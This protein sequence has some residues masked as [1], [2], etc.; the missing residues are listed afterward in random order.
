MA[1]AT[2]S[3]TGAP[4]RSPSHVEDIHPSKVSHGDTALALLADGELQSAEPVELKRLVRKIDWTILPFLSVCYAFYYIDK[5]TLSYAAIFGIKEDLGLAGDQYSW[6][7][8][9]F[10]FG[11]LVW[12]LPTNFLLQRF[13][14]GKYLGV[15]I[16]LWGA[17]LMLQA[18]AKN[19]T[20]LAV[21][22][23]ISGA[24]EACSDP[25]FMLITSM[26][27]TRRQQPIRIGLW[28]TANGAGIA[29]GG[30]LGY[31]IGQIQGALSSWKYEFLIIGALC[32][33]WGIV[34]A[35]FL[36]DSPVM[37]Q[38]FSPREKRL[39]VER[40]REN[41]T[42][43]ENKTLK[44]AQVL[45]ALLDWKVWVF[46]L[47]G[48]SGNIP[49]GGISNFGTLIIQ[50]FGFSTLITTL[51]QIPYGA[52][53]SIMILLSVFINDRLPPNNRCITAIFFLLPNVAGA[54]GLCFLPETEKVGRLICYY[55]TGSYN[56]SFVLILSILTGNIAGHTKKVVTN[57]MI[58]LGVCGG[59]IAGPF[60]YKSNQAP[61]YTLGIWS[62]IVANFLEIALILVLRVMLA[63]EN[64]R[65]DAMRVE[66]E[67]NADGDGDET[68]FADLTDKEN[69][70]FRYV[71]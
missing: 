68:A 49:N 1:T 54:F 65:R 64:R 8:S 56:A 67:G 28:Y 3:L 19:F 26:W 5:T 16:F 50:G 34:I 61:R 40:L 22:R 29:L 57:A 41:Q 37:A 33:S 30:L 6:L 48:F 23:V 70:N 38:T 69:L 36:P 44:P 14:V 59:N 27:Y 60:F 9:V 32:A 11:F 43:V 35:I 4:K 25:A 13:P 71:Y 46:L 31:G 12:A 21:L 7:S 66:W 55:L 52:F 58:F 10:Y 18:A 47:L 42:G 17:F 2:G 51:M 45:E 20:Q 62:M 24:A 53:T 63:W 15:N 39:A